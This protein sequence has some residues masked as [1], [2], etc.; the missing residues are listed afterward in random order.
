MASY[1]LTRLADQDLENILRFGVEQFGLQPALTY[2]DRLQ[3]RFEEIAQSPLQY[4]SLSVLSG[5]YRRSVCGAHAIYFIIENHSVLIVR[6]I[7]QQQ[8]ELP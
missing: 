3:R 4:P 6:V 1:R 8:F 7:H 2:Y 5:E